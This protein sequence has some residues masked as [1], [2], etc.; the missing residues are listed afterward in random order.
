MS[1]NKNLPSGSPAPEENRDGDCIA[2]KNGDEEIK[3]R[4]DRLSLGLTSETLSHL[5]KEKNSF[6]VAWLGSYLCEKSLRNPKLRRKITLDSEQ[7]RVI[8]ISGTQGLSRATR[9]SFTSSAA[10]LLM[11][12]KSCLTV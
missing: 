3:K 2:P 1:E 10:C 5:C 9:S 6:G 12:K 7:P 8:D 4:D 11:W